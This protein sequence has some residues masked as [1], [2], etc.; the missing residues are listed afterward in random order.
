MSR[1]RD[2]L[3]PVLHAG[4]DALHDNRRAK[5]RAVKSGSD[6]AVGAL[7]HLF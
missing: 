3:F 5:Y 1:Q 4:L 7:P 6:R 2:R